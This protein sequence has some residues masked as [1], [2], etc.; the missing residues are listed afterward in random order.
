MDK[1][2]YLEN[3]FNPDDSLGV[4]FFG[5]NGWNAVK[6]AVSGY[7]DAAL[8]NPVLN[9]PRKHQSAYNEFYSK[10]LRPDV[11]AGAELL[12]ASWFDN[13][14]DFLS[15]KTFSVASDI[16]HNVANIASYIPYVG[17]YVKGGRKI[18]NL[19]ADTLNALGFGTKPETIKTAA[20]GG[21]AL[22]L[23]GSGVAIWYFGFYKKKKRR[24]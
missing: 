7:V 22:L 18:T 13:A 10:L 19:A 21:G 1:K 6:G 14:S 20:V 2:N 5:L 12:G 17:D 15:S 4:K 16:G 11:E 3:L 8:N 23:I 24:R 9:R